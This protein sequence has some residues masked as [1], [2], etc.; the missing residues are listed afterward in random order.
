MTT[1]PRAPLGSGKFLRFCKCSKNLKGFYLVACFRLVL[2]GLFLGSTDL[3][4]LDSC[5]V[6]WVGPRGLPFP[7]LPPSLPC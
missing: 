6:S 5:V 2:M 7:F 4:W 3:P 1:V